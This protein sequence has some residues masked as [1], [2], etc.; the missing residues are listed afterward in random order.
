MTPAA[1]FYDRCHGLIIKRRVLLV[2]MNCDN[3]MVLAMIIV[4]GW[5]DN[6]LFF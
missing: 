5:V 3:S 2:R 1:F 6:L 4:I